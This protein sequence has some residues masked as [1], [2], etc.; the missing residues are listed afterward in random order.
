MKASVRMVCAGCL[1]SV[2]VTSGSAGSSPNQCHYCGGPV[3]SHSSQVQ[4]GESVEEST[5]MRST[6]SE[7]DETIDWTKTWARGSLGSL[8]RF[9]LRE[10]LGDGGFGQVFRA[11][12]PRLDRD[13]A[14]KVL[15]QPDPAERVMERFFREAR[16]AARLDHPNIVAVHDAGYDNGRCWVAYQLVGGRPLSWY[17]DHHQMDATTVA[18]IMRALADALDHSHHMGVV[19]RDIKPGNVLIDDGGRPRLIDFGLARRSDFESDLTRDGAIVGTPAYMS[20]EQALGRSR[21]ADERSD[22]YSLGVILY[23]LLYGRLPDERRT[24]LTPLPGGKSA[25][26]LAEI[27]DRPSRANSAVPPILRKICARATAIDPSA[28]HPTARALADELEQWLEQQKIRRGRIARSGV[29]L[30][31]VAAAIL[32]LMSFVTALLAWKSRTVSPADPLVRGGPALM[33]QAAVSPPVSSSEN[34]GRL[35][36]NLEKHRYHRLTCASAHSMSDRNRIPFADALEAAA[37]GFT[38]CEKCRPPVAPPT[39]DTEAA[40]PA[41]GD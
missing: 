18:Q 17:C 27:G 32:I 33:P 9:Q 11:Y 5:L 39:S 24:A 6:A 16:A 14:V 2:E 25:H 28:R 21:Q 22:V 19:H 36:G 15:K 26:S 7:M 38:P 40:R 37:R 8:G 29:P 30:V 23:E 34:L 31:P 20:P 3:D 13:V 10:R 4:P 35:V 12:D 41:D 1:R